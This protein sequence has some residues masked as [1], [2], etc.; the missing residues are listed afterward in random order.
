MTQLGDLLDRAYRKLDSHDF[1]GAV[2]DYRTAAMLAVPDATT[3]AHLAQASEHEQLAFFEALRERHPDSELAWFMQARFYATMH[4]P[5]QA[6]DLYAKMFELFGATPRDRFSIHWDR[7]QAACRDTR[8]REALIVSDVQ[9][10]WDMG[11]AYAPARK[12]RWLLLKLLVREL[13][14]EASI[15]IFEALCG[16]DRFPESVKQLF[17]AKIAQLTALGQAIDEI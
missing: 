11:E 5:D 17:S 9:T 14:D 6:M 13:D 8:M 1:A 16:D 12:L 2:N 7:L 15:T 10:I 4:Y 3:L